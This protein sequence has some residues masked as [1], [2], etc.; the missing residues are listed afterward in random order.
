MLL[1]INFV[2][3]IQICH[4]CFLEHLFVKYYGFTSVFCSGCN[5]FQMN[6]CTR[7]AADTCVNCRRFVEHPKEGTI[8]EMLAHVQ[9][10][11]FRPD[12][13]M[14]LFVVFC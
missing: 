4:Y 1:C 2:I 3:Q 12:I 6:G 5:N 9:E 10:R 14:K 13:N 8:E 11:D 7:F